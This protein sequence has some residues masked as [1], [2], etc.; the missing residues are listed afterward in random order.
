MST[1][2]F[3]G[4]PR[5]RL[6]SCAF[7][8]ALLAL[9]G[10]C[11]ETLSADV[12]RDRARRFAE[13]GDCGSAIAEYRRLVGELPHD[14]D[15]HRGWVECAARSGDLAELV[16]EHRV[17][18]E[19]APRD[20]VAR[21][22]LGLA[23]LAA[24]G[25]GEK[26]GAAAWLDEAAE[27]DP[28]EAEYRY[29]AGLAWLLAGEAEK[30]RERLEQAL[31]LAP[32]RSRYYPAA[33]DALLRTGQRE[34]A[35]EL[36][37]SLVALGP[38]LGDVR[39]GREAL[40]LAVAPDRGLNASMKAELTATL[41][42]L[43]PGG[44]V[45][46]ALRTIEGLIEQ[47]PETPI[48]HQARGLA[49]ERMGRHSEAIVSLRRSAELAPQ[50]AEPHRGLAAVLAALGRHDEAL[51]QYRKAVELDPLSEDAR[52]GIAQILAERG[53]FERAAEVLRELVLLTGGAAG[54]R[55]W[56]ARAL[57]GYGR[58][59]EAEVELRAVL[60]E[61]P[62]HPAALFR[63]ASL[64]AEAGFKLPPGDRQEAALLEA[65]ALV[66]RLL[67]VSPG[68]QGAQELVRRLAGQE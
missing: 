52:S 33:V 50:W 23:R 32:D 11:A 59:Q 16:A 58:D 56:L 48:L 30:A 46:A 34:R 5:A 66:E 54:A 51:V 49:M 14:L 2:R 47:Q 25:E 45:E 22:V 19:R 12:R 18:A 60:D 36:L 53:D 40:A 21:Y 26:A 39:L 29:R 61:Q 57:S 4:G 10:G 15:A 62:A 8:A 55:L 31:N 65:R 68:H 13:A 27:L 35:L 41:E 17:R 3:D 20:A 43:E 9:I 37:A 44:D 6:G 7:A 38:R 1:G 67:E 24:T 42:Q 63:L 28:G 64:R